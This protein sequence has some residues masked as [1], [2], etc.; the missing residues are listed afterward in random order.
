MIPERARAGPVRAGLLAALLTLV[1]A[2]RAATV[3]PDPVD[4]DEIAMGRVLSPPR[5]LPPTPVPPD[6]PPTV[7]KIALGRKLFFDRRLSFNGTMSCGMCHVP[8]Q[9]F[10]SNELATPIGV[11]GRSLRRNAPTILNVAYAGRLFHDGRETSLENQVL[12]PLLSEDEMANPS[13]GWVTSRLDT[14]PDYAGLFEAAFGTGPSADRIGQAIASW[15]RT[16]LAGDS[17]FDRWYYGREDDALTDEQKRGFELFTG[18]ARCVACHPVGERAAVLTDGRFRDTGV[19]F[20][21]TGA[22]LDGRAVPVEISPGVVVPVAHDLVR[23]VGNERAPDLG[24][25]ELTLDPED[26]WR[27]RTPSLR[28]VALTAPYMHDGSLRT[29]LDVVRF[30]D[31]GGNP[32]PGLDPLIRPLALSE[33][34]AAA[35]VAFLESLTGRG[36]DEL[37][38]DARSVDVGN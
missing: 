27:Y 16:L 11:E 9:G 2:G 31:R 37:V 19:G 4:R 20:Q 7:E 35:L 22:R 3:P 33:D 17:P 29:L 1:P 32:H 12:G 10:T 25:F 24:R 18:R 6:N 13:I 14:L 21:R 15:E 26:R 23:S 28:N 36:I 34:E 30:Y 8:E 5:G 38:A